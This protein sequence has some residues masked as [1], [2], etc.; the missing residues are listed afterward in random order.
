M[1][2]QI[3]IDRNICSDLSGY[4]L[5]VPYRP[6]AR[7]EARRLDTR[8]KVV[9]AALGLLADGGYQAATMADV[10]R[11]AEVGIGTLY[12]QFPSKPE[13]FR[14]AYRIASSRELQ[15]VA[16][17]LAREGSAADRMALAV[18]ES[19]GRALTGRTLGRVLLVEPADPLVE[20]ERLRFRADYRDLFAATIAEG[21]QR[22]EFPPQDPQLSATALMGA[23][24]EVLFG[25]I[26]PVGDET[27]RRSDQ[28]AEAL[29]AHCRGA[30]N[31]SVG[32]R[33]V[34][35]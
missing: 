15:V 8:S 23:I 4:S 27:N 17:A 18:R 20:A 9:S 25:P 21:I 28:V 6:T 14:E 16:E 35:P 2:G 13:L 29:V 22:G 11:L 3:N 19:A 10:A 5:G 12:R 24:V 33:P 31:A 32:V 34:A 26:S 30:L 7:T 1:C